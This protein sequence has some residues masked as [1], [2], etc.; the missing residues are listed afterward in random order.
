MYPQISHNSRKQQPEAKDESVRQ[1]VQQEENLK[2]VQP[3]GNEAANIQFMNQMLRDANADNMLDLSEYADQETVIVPFEEKVSSKKPAI[4]DKISNNPKQVG[5]PLDESDSSIDLNN[6]MYLNSSHNIVNEDWLDRVKS[7]KKN[8]KAQKPEKEKNPDQE[9]VKEIFEIAEEVVQDEIKQKGPAKESEK[10]SEPKK[11]EFEPLSTYELDEDM[12]VETGRKKNK[13]KKKKNASEPVLNN[14]SRVKGVEGIEDARWKDAAM[15]RIKK[16]EL[17][18]GKEATDAFHAE[19]MEKIKNWS[20]N[21]EKLNKVKKTSKFRRFL[22]WTAAGF[23]KLL[24]KAL[25]IITLGHFWRAKSTLRFAFTNTKK[26]QT[27]KEYKNIPGWDGAQFDPNANKGEDVLADFRRVPTVWSRLTAAKAAEPVKKDG[28]EEEKPLDPVVSILVDQ[29]KTGSSRSM[30]SD[31]MG[32]TMLGIEYSRKSAVSGRYER[33]KLQYGFYP[34][35]GT[36]GTSGGSVMQL[37]NAVLPGQLVDDY[38]HQYDISRSYPAKSEQVSKIFRASEKYAEGGYS[39]YDRNCTTFVKEMVVNIAHLATGGDIFKQSEVRFSNLGNFGMFAAEAFDQNTKAGAENLLMDLTKKNDQSYQNYGNKRATARDWVNYKESM[40]KGSSLTKKTYV[41]AEV[42][43][44]MRRMEGDETGEIGSYKFND[45]LKAGEEGNDNILVGLRKISSGIEQI[46]TQIQENFEEI[47]PAEQQQNAPFEIAT[48]ANTLSGMGAPLESLD[49]EINRNLD[50]SNREKEGDKKLKREEIREQF[51]VTPVMLRQTRKELSDNISKV[52]ILLMKYFKN[53]KR[54]HQP[55]LNL[56]SLLNYGIN[57]VDDLYRYSVRGGLDEKKDVINI[58]E[59]MMHNLYTVRADGKEAKFTPTHYESYIQIYKDPKIAV[60]KYA[61]LRDLRNKKKNADWTKSK[62]S[63]VSHKIQSTFGLED[64]EG[65]TYAELKEL[66]KLERM[67]KLAL[68][69]DNAHNYMIEKEDYNQQDIDYAFRMHDKETNGLQTRDEVPQ[70]QEDVNEG[71]RDQY[72]SAS[73]IYITLFMEK[74]FKDIKEQWMKG[75][76]E[77]GL[78]EDASK[79]REMSAAWLDDYLANRIKQKENDFQMI[80]RGLYRSMKAGDPNKKIDD[81]AVMEKLAEVL[82]WTIIARKFSSVGGEKKELFGSMFLPMALEQMSV[83]R[84]M[85]FNQIV[86]TMIRVC[87][88]E[89]KDQTLTVMN[90]H[91][92]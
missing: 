75:A 12:R 21:A 64:E 29:P 40:S 48:I 5:K 74:F 61:R 57:Y 9:D 90:N 28:K 54:L 89:E 62:M 30:E 88:M 19:E 13:K 34:A 60:A 11:D 24:G 87:Q 65:L 52:N 51:F 47:L 58:R 63:T 55:L 20:F 77:G 78:N 17:D 26:W 82:T 76:D 69:F 39:Y 35:G 1:E 73:G 84:R 16:V 92:H 44:Q 4:P 83:N 80:V 18:S 45:P 25:Q 68:D 70:A 86:S 3:M 49:L 53:D 14:T 23:G 15:K 33:Y 91:I 38:G 59:E 46:G 31:E 2:S 56:I 6:S 22:T 7:E 85:K 66:N 81:K 10:V 71:M 41:P 36:T 37:H 72:K 67:D 50:K 32:H 79:N 27:T 8:K 42:G 43:E